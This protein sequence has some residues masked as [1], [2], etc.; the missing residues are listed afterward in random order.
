MRIG[1]LSGCSHF[2]KK[3]TKALLAAKKVHAK[4]EKVKKRKEA[5]K[6]SRTGP[7]PQVEAKKPAR[8]SVSFA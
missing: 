2:L 4:R 1:I 3:E 8:K 6:L 7:E 5:S